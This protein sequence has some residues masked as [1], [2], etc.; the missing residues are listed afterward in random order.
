MTDMIL[1][2][3][4]KGFLENIIDMFKKDETLYPVLISMLR[5]ER[6]RVRIGATALVE[7]LMKNLQTPFILKTAVEV[8]VYPC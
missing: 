7:E 4:D 3:M 5:D 2:H 1:D 6:M 8:H